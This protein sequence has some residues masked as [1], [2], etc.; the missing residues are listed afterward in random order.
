MHTMATYKS[1]Y[2]ISLHLTSPTQHTSWWCYQNEY[3]Y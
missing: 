3:R 2:N 1:T